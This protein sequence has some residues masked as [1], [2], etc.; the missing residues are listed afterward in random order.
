MRRVLLLGVLGCLLLAGCGGGGGGGDT[1]PTPTVTGV[2]F[3]S[4]VAGVDY[5][6]SGGRQGTTDAVGEFTCG[7]GDTVVFSVGGIALGEVSAAARVTVFDLA[8]AD[9]PDSRQLQEY[10]GNPIGDT[11]WVDSV[12][13]IGDFPLHRALNMASFLQTLDDDMDPE[14]G[15]EIAA[16]TRVRLKAATYRL[17]FALSQVEFTSRLRK[18]LTQ[19]GIPRSPRKPLAVVRHLVNSGVIPGPF[20]RL[21]NYDIQRDQGGNLRVFFGFDANGNLNRSERDDNIDGSIDYFYE[22]NF[23]TQGNLTRQRVYNNQGSVDDLDSYTYDGNANLTRYELDHTLDGTIGALGAYTC[24]SNGNQTRTERDYDGDGKNDQVEVAV[25]DASGNR[26]WLETDWNGDGTT[27]T[28]ESYS[29]DTQGNQTGILSDYD[30]DGV[31]DRDESISYN[32]DGNPVSDS[33]DWNM[34]GTIDWI[35]TWKYDS[36]GNVVSFSV[37][38][39]ND[40]TIDETGSY[41]YDSAGRLIHFESG[42]VGGSVT[43]RLTN[44]YDPDG[45]MI[46]RTEW[47][48]DIDGTIDAVVVKTYDAQGNLVALEDSRT[49]YPPTMTI[50]T[51]SYEPVSTFSFPQLEYLFH[52]KGWP[53]VP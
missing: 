48:T 18:V 16:D 19:A 41:A 34:D 24:D 33:V 6:C 11:T 13:A 29:Y 43:N 51:A 5:S 2:L 14:N 40:G 39:N 45:G 21:V 12:V 46:R 25:F 50:G 1:P 10:I 30:A 27:D 38:S 7:E 52:P 9:Q 3:D 22:Y 42:P 35:E 37:D 44:A 8:E 53:F 23:N 20:Q 4:A 17:N 28:R 15:I 36:E 31:I 26:L 32:T 49:M 47:D